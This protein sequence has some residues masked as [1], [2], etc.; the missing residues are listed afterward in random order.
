MVEKVI[1]CE[2]Y[3]NQEQRLLLT[4]DLKTQASSVQ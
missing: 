3:K 1:G 2:D 4:V